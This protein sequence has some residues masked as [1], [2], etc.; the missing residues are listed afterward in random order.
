MSV[1]ISWT[2]VHLKSILCQCEESAVSTQQSNRLLGL[3]YQVLKCMYSQIILYLKK[4]AQ[5]FVKTCADFSQNPRRFWKKH[6][7]VW[8]MV[9]WMIEI[10]LDSLF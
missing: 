3:F 2:E 8:L 7:R 5:T 1:E 10:I 6:Q 4:P 9:S